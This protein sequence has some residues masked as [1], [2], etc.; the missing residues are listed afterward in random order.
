MPP[1]PRMAPTPWNV[2]SPPSPFRLIVVVGMPAVGTGMAEAEL[3]ADADPAVVTPR[4]PEATTRQET[5]VKVTE[6]DRTFQRD[7]M[8]PICRLDPEFSREIIY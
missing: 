8:H 6:V 5:M 2:L 4:L 1:P 3:A 7:T